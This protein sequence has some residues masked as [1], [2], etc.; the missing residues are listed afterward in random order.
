MRIGVLALQGAFIE[1]I[2]QLGRLGVQTQQVRLPEDLEGL[3]ALIIPGGESTAIGK[4]MVRYGLMEP[5]RS[6]AR[7]HA[8]WGTCA[9]M[10][11]MAKEIGRD[12]PLLDLMDIVVERNA[13]GR[14]IDS[15]IEPLTVAEL[16]EG[17]TLPFPAIFI[18][19]PRLVEARGQA[20]I[21]ARLKN[22]TAVAAVEGQWLVTSFHPEL[23]DDLRF[24]E[25][26]VELALNP[27]T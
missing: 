27:E 24:H 19:A 16:K 4:L 18:R 8:L 6:F 7:Q 17:G 2:H 15:F 9:G 20:R 5:I 13:F 25:Y 12:Q 23:S 22:D 1:H 10:I 26:F 11:L 14:Q 3:Q 21:L